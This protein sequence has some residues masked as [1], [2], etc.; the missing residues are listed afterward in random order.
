MLE[1]ANFTLLSSRIYLLETIMLP[2]GRPAG[3]SGGIDPIERSCRKSWML[4]EGW[5]GRRGVSRWELRQSTFL[6]RSRSPGKCSLR[7][8]R[9]SEHPSHLPLIEPFAFLR[10][11]CFPA[12][13]AAR[14]WSKERYHTMT[15]F[16]DEK[17]LHQ[18]R[19][20]RLSRSARRARRALP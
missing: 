8:R 1:Q 14:S 3:R 6:D 20:L 11:S 19:G 17:A 15:I 12:P 18:S 13:P 9:T 2:I 4:D 5:H 10:G 7:Y 16:P